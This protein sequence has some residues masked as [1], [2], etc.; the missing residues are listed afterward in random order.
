MKQEI[1]ILW[2]DALDSEEFVQGTGALAKWVGNPN[3]RQFR[4]CCLG[5]LCEV[6]VRNGLPLEIEETN[7]GRMYNGFTAYLPDAVIEWAGM[8]TETHPEYPEVNP[9]TGEIVGRTSFATANDS[10][11]VTFPELAKVIRANWAAIA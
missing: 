11:G 1:A 10:F 8:D 6:A 7:G 4:H 2:A 9:D 3:R 5:V